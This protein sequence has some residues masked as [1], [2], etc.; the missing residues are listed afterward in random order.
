MRAIT[1]WILLLL[2]LPRNYL[3]DFVIAKTAKQ[4]LFGFYN[5]DFE[6]VFTF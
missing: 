4:L 5:Y 1:I 6:Y 3:L 2:K